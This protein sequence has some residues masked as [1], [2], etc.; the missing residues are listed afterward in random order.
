MNEIKCNLIIDSCCDLPRE[1]VEQEHVYLIEFPYFYGEE[2]HLDDL[3]QTTTA[4]D[5][6]DGMRKGATPHTSG[7]SFEML[8]STY[9]QVIAEGMPA[10][11]LSF[12][13]GL[14]GHFDQAAR[15]LDIVRQEHPDAELHLVDSR[16][17]CTPEGLFV[18]EAIRQ[19]KQGLTAR[20]LADWAQE[21]RNYVTTYFMVDN[22]EALKRGGRIP[23]SVAF[24]GTKMNVKPLLMFALDGSLAMKGF[25]RGR[26]KGIKQLFELYREHVDKT[27]GG[28]IV[29]IGSAD[30]PAKDIERL[31]EMVMEESNGACVIIE[32]SIGPVIGSHVGPDMM[33]IAFWGVDRR[34]E[35]S[36]SDR[37]AQ[38]VKGEG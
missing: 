21:A 29:L 30:A 5:F 6:Y 10:V 24:A 12:T 37:I 36:L 9:E 19:Q 8:K 13:S 31:K 17:A 34:Q 3:W 23:S 32:H 16:V 22:L 18:L 28:E 33:S 38:K 1:M 25:A 27:A 2:E 14:S 7:A 11:Y 20:Q 26:K 4:H 35:L 15:V